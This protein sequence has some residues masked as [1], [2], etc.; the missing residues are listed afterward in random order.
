MFGFTCRSGEGQAL[1]PLSL[2]LSLGL[3]LV[4]VALGGAAVGGEML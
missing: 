3:L 2:D 1:Q 4:Q